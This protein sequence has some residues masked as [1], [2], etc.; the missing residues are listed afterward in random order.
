MKNWNQV[1]FKS[2]F[3]QLQHC[4]C[5]KIR[6]QLSNSPLWRDFYICEAGD[7]G[8]VV[9]E[10]GMRPSDFVTIEYTYFISYNAI[11]AIDMEEI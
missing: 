9:H 8:M 10:Y 1:D 4:F 7:I 3:N 2:I 5:T 6:M 11:V